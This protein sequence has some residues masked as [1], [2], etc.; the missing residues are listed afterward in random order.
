MFSSPQLRVTPLTNLFTCLIL[1]TTATEI[2]AQR[3][4]NFDAIKIK[5][6]SGGG[7]SVYMLQGRGG[8]IGVSIF[9]S[10][11]ISSVIELGAKRALARWAP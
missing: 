3:H 9:S 5:N 8:N 6:A 4:R 11:P 10:T 2:Q 1:F 7:H